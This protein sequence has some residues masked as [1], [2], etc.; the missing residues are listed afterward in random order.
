MPDG[1]P[2]DRAITKPGQP[3][4]P[5]ADDC[6]V[7]FTAPFQSVKHLLW[8][9][10]APRRPNRNHPVQE[11]DTQLR[12]ELRAWDAASDEALREFEDRLPEQGE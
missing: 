8:N 6:A 12:D 11:L 5:V 10:P 2:T 4:P 3:L 9:Y 1:T 7:S